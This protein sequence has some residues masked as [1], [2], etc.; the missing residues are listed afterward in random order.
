FIAERRGFVSYISNVTASNATRT[1]MLNISNQIQFDNSAVDGEMGLESVEFH[2]GFATNGYFFVS[3]IAPGGNPYVFRLSRFTADPMTLTV[4]T[5]SQVILFNITKREFNHCGGDLHFGN[6]G[7]LYISMGD[8][9]GQYNLR[10]N[11]QRLDLGLYA[12]V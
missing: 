1:V 3:Y 10:T 12:G 8:E 5:N 9:G 7:Y 6:D 2:P 11:A 4:D